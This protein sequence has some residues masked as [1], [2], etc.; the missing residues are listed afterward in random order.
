MINLKI[1]LKFRTIE[2][3]LLKLESEYIE[4]PNARNIK[5]ENEAMDVEQLGSHPRHKYIKTRIA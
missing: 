4:K 1:I 2:E 3:Y 5:K